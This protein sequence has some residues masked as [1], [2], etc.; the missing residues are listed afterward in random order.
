[1]ASVPQRDRLANWFVSQSPRSLATIPSRKTSS[2]EISLV[3]LFSR[4]TAFFRRSRTIF[5]TGLGRAENSDF[6]ASG[7]NVKLLL[8]TQVKEN[9]RKQLDLGRNSERTDR[10]S[11]RLNSSHR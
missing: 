9:F 2:S 6:M 8:L 4:S 3:W 5:W 7:G 11:T 10:K 1:M